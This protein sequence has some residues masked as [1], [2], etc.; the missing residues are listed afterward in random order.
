VRAVGECATRSAPRSSL[1]EGVSLREDDGILPKHGAPNT[2]GY[3]KVLERRRLNVF[4]VRRNGGLQI[5]LVAN[6]R[7][8][9]LYDCSGRLVTPIVDSDA[10]NG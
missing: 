1:Q 6:H 5:G 4:D 2:W 9:K 10:I 8:V 7:Q 3:H